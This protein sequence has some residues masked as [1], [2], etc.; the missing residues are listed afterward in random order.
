[1]SSVLTAVALT[2]GNPPIDD[3]AQKTECLDRMMELVDAGQALDLRLARLLAWFKKQDLAPLGVPSYTAFCAERIEWKSTWLRQLVRL[4]SSDLPCVKAAVC[5][6]AL[7]MTVAVLAPSQTDAQDEAYWL[8]RALDGQVRPV[9]RMREAVQKVTLERAEAKTVHRA[10]QLARLCMGR[11]VSD[12]V[13]DR[14]VLSAF[15][16][17]RDGAEILAEA[18]ETPPAPDQSLLQSWCDKADPATRLIGPWETPA[19]LHHGLKLLKAVQHARRHRI[20]E[21]GYLYS[22]VASERLYR[23]WGFE[24]LAEMCR[25][26]FDLSVRTLERYRLLGDNASM[27]PEIGRALAHGLELQRAETLSNIAEEST[28]ERWLAIAKRTGTQE[29]TRAA[30]LAADIGAEPVLQAYEQAMAS[31]TE[32]VALRAANTPPKAPNY[33]VVHPELVEAAIWF[34]DQVKPERQYGF[35]K[36]KERADYTCENPECGHRSLRIHSHHIVFQSHGG[37]NDPSNAVA[38]CPACHLRLIHT[39]RIQVRR[40]G[41]LLIWTFPGR[42][43]VS[44]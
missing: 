38:L 41:E 36:V 5:L 35:G 31:T 10:R 15:R 33:L 40:E 39:G 3:Q 1:M 17:Q 13:A 8:I 14:F 19:D 20:V 29:L 9:R 4:A 24:S 6:G 37:S 34:L 43:V 21:L 28:V 30:Q 18:R 11:P 12:E 42:V 7:P 32:T 27:L 2:G 25:E 26:A 23:Q 44:C 22:R 16:Q